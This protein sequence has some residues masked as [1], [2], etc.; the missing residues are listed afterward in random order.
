MSNLGE[1]VLQHGDYTVRGPMPLSAENIEKLWQQA[2]QYPQIFGKEVLGNSK[3]FIEL[4]VDFD[5]ANPSINGLFFVV[6]DFL[7]VFYLTDIVPGDDALAHYTFFDRRHTGRKELVV[8]MMKYVFKK[9]KFN[10]LTAQVPNYATE[11]ARHFIQSCGFVY[12]G[13]RR[14]AAPYKGDMFDINLYGIL[15][16][17]VLRNG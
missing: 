10:R 8:E 15:R 5:G 3:D 16:S 9:Y 4:F 2:K 17:E 12:E 7:G 13:K 11:Q 6:N 14:K 1:I